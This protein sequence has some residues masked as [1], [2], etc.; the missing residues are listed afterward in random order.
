MEKTTITKEELIK[1]LNDAIDFI[2]EED[3]ETSS[4]SS[5]LIH[6]SETLDFDPEEVVAEWAK[7]TGVNF[8]AVDIP[9]LTD[10][11]VAEL[12]NILKTPTVFLYKNYGYYDIDSKIYALRSNYRSLLKD[13]IYGLFGTPAPNFLFAVATIP[14]GTEK[15]IDT[16][17]RLGFYYHLN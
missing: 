16:S 8:A 12:P 10:N 11:D 7:Q 9:K 2:R 4:H 15:N 17:E 1:K 14:S 6:R 3:Y 5:I 13:R